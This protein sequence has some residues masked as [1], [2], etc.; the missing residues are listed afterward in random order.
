MKSLLFLTTLLCLIPLSAQA[1]CPKGDPT[2][3]SYIRRDENRCEGL[4]DRRDASGSLMLISFVTTNLTQI[5]DPLNIR[6]AGNPKPTLEVQELTRNYRLD[7]VKM[8]SKGN[9]AQFSLNPKI[10]SKSGIK[11]VNSLL[12]IAY[13]IH[14]SSPIYYPTIL[15][16]ASSS[17][18]FVLYAPK[19][20]IFK[21]IQIRPKNNSK[22]YFSQSLSQPRE[23]QIPF[24]WSHGNAP[25]GDYE[26][27]VEDSKGN[28]RHFQFQHN[29]KWL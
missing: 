17:Y 14:S 5:S 21:T 25:A 15:G 27:Y 2:K 24:Q 1:S 8:Q 19:A 3:L 26:L 13:T 12:A 29:P 16:N 20:T 28:Q 4:R 10:L 11:T 23:G 7:D 18:T 9:S 6:V 22:I